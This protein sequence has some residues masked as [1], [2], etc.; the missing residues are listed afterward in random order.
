MIPRFDA[1][2]LP[3]QLQILSLFCFVL[4]CF[5]LKPTKFTVDV[6]LLLLVVGPVLE[7]S[8]PN[9]I[10]TPL[11]KTDL[12]PPPA[13]IKCLNNSSATGGTLCQHP[14]LHAWIL[15]GLSLHR[16]FASSHSFCELVCATALL[17]LG[18]TAFL[19]LSPTS[20]FSTPLYLRIPE[21]WD[22]RM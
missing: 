16:P 11:K 22:S 9:G 13:S 7:C 19:K 12:P 3:T 4:C 15:C 21:P 1:T 5:S 8:W 2:S 14:P 6:T 18:N 10:I 17:C 20:G